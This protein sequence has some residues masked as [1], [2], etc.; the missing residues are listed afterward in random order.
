MNPLQGGLLLE[1]LQQAYLMRGKAREGLGRKS[2]ATKDYESVLELRRAE[3]MT[4]HT[5]QMRIRV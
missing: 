1:R 4:Q 3:L 5:L 2:E